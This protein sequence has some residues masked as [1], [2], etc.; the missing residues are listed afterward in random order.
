[1]SPTDTTAAVLSDEHIVAYID[2][3]LS[4]DACAQIEAILA[5]SPDARARLAML[6][7]GDR[8]FREALDTV[9]PQAPIARLLAGL[10]DTSAPTPLH[11]PQSDVR[12]VPQTTPRPEP[13]VSHVTHSNWASLAAAASVL[14]ALFGGFMGGTLFPGSATNDPISATTPQLATAPAQTTPRGWRQAVA[15]YQILF[16][17]DSLTPDQGG[18]AGLSMANATLGLPLDGV[19][20]DLDTLNF[21]RVQ[22]LGFNGKALVQLAY[23][24]KDGQPVSFCVIASGKPDAAR[25]FET[26]NGLGIVHWISGGFG[27]MLIGNVAETAL[28]QMADQLGRRVG[29]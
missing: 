13:S 16:N 29:I 28:S 10:Y 11:S 25:A 7:S 2:G 27:F 8:P 18:D 17:E 1:M 3:A 4:Q 20:T 24:S 19:A 15:D 6:E 5:E 9:L 21:R 14:V 26:R 23:L 22:V 12:M